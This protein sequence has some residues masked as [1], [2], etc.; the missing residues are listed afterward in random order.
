MEVV[1]RNP[2]PLYE[3]EC[4]ECNSVIRFQAGE[5]DAYEHITCPVCGVKTPVWSCYRVE[6][7]VDD[8]GD[9]E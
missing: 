3:I 4:H 6:T 8:V 7:E 9:K 1:K 2:I 5:V